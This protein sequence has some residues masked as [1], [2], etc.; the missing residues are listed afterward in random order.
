MSRAENAKKYFEEGHACAQAVVMAFSDLMYMDSDG[1]ERMMLPFGGGIG[2]QRLTCGAVS[3]MVA[4]VG[5]LY[6][7]SGVSHDNKARVYEIVR[8]LCDRFI[9]QRASLVCGELLNMAGIDGSPGGSP[10]TRDPDYYKKRPCG[11][12]VY[13]AADILE[14]YINE[15]PIKK[16]N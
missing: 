11:E 5:A 2:R 8:L 15:N 7:E 4:V 16:E 1:L 6:A 12:L 14:Q 3:G 13:V 9:Q 10:E